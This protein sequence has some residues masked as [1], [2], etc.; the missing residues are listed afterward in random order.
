MTGAILNIGLH[1]ADNPFAILA[2][3][4]H[5]G[6]TVVNHAV[7][8]QTLVV[9][10]LPATEYLEAFLMAGVLRLADALGRQAIA[11]YLPAD[12]IGAVVG[13]GANEYGSFDPKAFRLQGGG[14][15]Q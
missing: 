6:M 5:H 8:D 14:T 2:E 3:A 10:V 11:V 9:G 13:R 1:P 4:G 15:L 7:V 12:D